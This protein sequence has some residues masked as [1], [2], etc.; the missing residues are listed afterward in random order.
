M[1]V[2]EALYSVVYCCFGKGRE[3]KF[4]VTITI[5]IT[6][7]VIIVGKEMV[8]ILTQMMG[9]IVI[10]ILILITIAITIVITMVIT[11]SKVKFTHRRDGP[12]IF[13]TVLL[14]T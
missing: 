3:L 7:V 9:T 4:W 11:I 5:T 6:I 8:T 13:Y 10:A 1:I 14:V 2:L 12:R